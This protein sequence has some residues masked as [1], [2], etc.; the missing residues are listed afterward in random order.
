[1]GVVSSGVGHLE[2]S[3]TLR[4]FELGVVKGP[5]HKTFN[6]RHRVGLTTL[7]INCK[8]NYDWTD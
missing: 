7:K 4:Q 6:F 8:F 3:F 5:L 1:L 2:K